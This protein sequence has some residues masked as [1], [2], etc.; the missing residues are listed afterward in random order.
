M[1]DV[2]N[3][4]SPRMSPIEKYI[5]IIKRWCCWLLYPH[6]FEKK[7]EKAFLCYKAKHTL[8]QRRLAIL[9]SLLLWTS[10]YYWDFVHKEV[11]DLNQ[12]L[13]VRTIGSVALFCL[14]LISAMDFI[15]LN[16]RLAERILLA[17]AVLIF[18]GILILMLMTQAPYN[19]TDYVP[20]LMLLYFA[21]FCF[22]WLSPSFAL[23]AGLSMMVPFQ[24]VEW[25]IWQGLPKGQ[26]LDL[27]SKGHMLYYWTSATFHLLA[28]IC[29]GYTI[30][31]SLER[32]LRQAFSRECALVESS[33]K[34]RL[35]VNAR[36]A[37][38][39][40]REEQAQHDL[41]INSIIAHEIKSPIHSLI[42]KTSGEFDELRRIQT[43]LE[44]IDRI[45]RMHG[46]NEKIL[47]TNLNDYVSGFAGT[48]FDI[49]VK[50]ICADPDVTAMLR[51]ELSYLVLEN[52]VINAE[53]FRYDG[54]AVELI[55]HRSLASGAPC[56]S[57]KNYGP[58]IPK[59]MLEGVFKMGHS[60]NTL[61]IR[62]SSRNRGI[63][64]FISKHYMAMQG[65]TLIALE[66]KDGA[67]FQL[68]FM[69][70]EVS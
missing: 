20:G 25:W 26:T 6:A 42:N 46:Q 30:V 52:L 37:L 12:L 39:Y 3:A 63:G 54:T 55:I 43:A 24:I 5:Q 66:S 61:A 69:R 14:L 18:I 57:V 58:T 16:E 10:F 65:G 2:A 4:Q 56:V 64:L 33:E 29:L 60:D 31:H 17:G 15:F 67:I 53:R 47:P 62:R 36:E 19:Y 59:E 7:L 28:V 22:L 45:D 8:K 13:L 41:R 48:I 35:A 44:A 9:L 49:P 70:V 32:G 50:V 38:L 11:A 40:E 1:Y 21:L 23:V 27:A 34:E 68:E 51:S